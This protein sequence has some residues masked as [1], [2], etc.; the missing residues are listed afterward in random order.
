MPIFIKGKQFNAKDI[1]DKELPGDEIFK[2]NILNEVFA[3]NTTFETR[4]ERFC[5]YALKNLIDYDYNPNLV[6]YMAL[7]M[8][9]YGGKRIPDFEITWIEDSY[10]IPGVGLLDRYSFLSH[11]LLRLRKLDLFLHSGVIYF[12]ALFIHT[13]ADPDRD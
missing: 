8:C 4:I 2:D 1:I 6:E 5:N 3:G 12:H 11:K 13:R 9:S 7:I 10:D